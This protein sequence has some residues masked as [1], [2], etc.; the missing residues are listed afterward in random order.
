[1]TCSTVGAITS[2]R[3]LRWFSYRSRATD[4]ISL[5]TSPNVIATAISPSPFGR[6]RATDTRAGEQHSSIRR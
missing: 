5:T 6:Q 2:N 1:L 4:G 3:F